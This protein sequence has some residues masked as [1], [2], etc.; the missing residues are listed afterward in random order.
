MNISIHF[1]FFNALVFCCAGLVTL[2]AMAREVISV[3]LQR[4]HE[5]QPVVISALLQLAPQPN[6]KALLI[7]PGWP[8]IPR[9]ETKEGVPSF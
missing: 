6:G 7:F 9:I 4:T 5:G 2:S 8:G 3:D 1:K